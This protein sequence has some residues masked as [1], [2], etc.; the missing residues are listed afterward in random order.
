MEIATKEQ[1]TEYF[2]D[3]ADASC[4]SCGFD[5][6][7]LHIFEDMFEGNRS[8]GIQRKKFCCCTVCVTT[9]ASNALRYPSQYDSKEVMQMLAMCTNMI[10][11]AIKEKKS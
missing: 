7:E 4:D 11:T 3:A 6:Q 1:L 5:T 9:F 2:G 10:L 8:H